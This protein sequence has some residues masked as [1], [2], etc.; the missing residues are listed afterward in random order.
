M[1]VQVIKKNG[2]PEWV[3]IPYDEYQRL[4][5]DIEMLQDVVAYDE[6]KKAVAEGEELIPSEV[7]FALIDG[8]NPVRV[9]REYRG[10]SR[11]QLA[12]TCGLT[13]DDLSEIESGQ[14]RGSPETLAA[15]A[16]KLG[17]EPDDLMES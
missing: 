2:K 13:E 4:I 5:N 10:L 7:T 16:R 14:R 1:S 9:W 17:L 15:I 11:K 8:A 12:E 3:V 6:A